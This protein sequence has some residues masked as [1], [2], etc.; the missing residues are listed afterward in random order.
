MLKNIYLQP[1]FI[2]VHDTLV[3][4][5]CVQPGQR[6]RTGQALLEVVVDGVGHFI[7]A[8]GNA[9]LRYIAVRENQYVEE[10]DLL[11]IIDT[12]E[13]GD[14]RPDAQEVNSHTE[15]GQEGR[16]GLEREGQRAFG[17]DVSGQLFDAPLDKNG[18]G[19]ERSVKQ[20]PLLSRMKEGVPP[21]MSH[22]ENNHQATERFAEDASN[23]PELQKQL[24]A[25]LEAQLQIG[26]QPT[27]APSLTRG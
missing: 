23:D 6:I 17:K 19:A 12:V 22:A 24:S 15:L 25:K 27:I 10:G 21:K 20:H 18:R 7:H 13:T 5:I 4:R 1:A 8:E 11:F 14:Y 26:S 9:W 2:G 3:K 16:R